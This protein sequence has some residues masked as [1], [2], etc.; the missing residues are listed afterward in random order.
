MLVILAFFVVY[1][2]FSGGLHDHAQPAGRPQPQS[3]CPAVQTS[4]SSAQYQWRRRGGE[5]VELVT[6]SP[7]AYSLYTISVCRTRVL[8]LPFFRFH[9]TMD[10]LGAVLL[11]SQQLHVVQRGFASLGH[12]RDV[13]DLEVQPAPAAV[14]VPGAEKVPVIVPA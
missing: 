11:P 14:S 10:T 1:T 9:L 13:V 5:R 6:P 3:S 8:P 2:D 4:L 7:P 12:G